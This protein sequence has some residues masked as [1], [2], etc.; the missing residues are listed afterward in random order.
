MILEGN[1]ERVAHG[2]YITPDAWEDKMMI[3]QL[4]KNKMIYSH[5]T[6]L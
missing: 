1:L 4:R 5:E 2:I 6:A 3:Y